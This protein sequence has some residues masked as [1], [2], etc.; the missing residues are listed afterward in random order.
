MLLFLSYCIII[1]DWYQ[2]KLLSANR[3]RWNQIWLP[4]KHLTLCFLLNQFVQA[5]KP[6]AWNVSWIDASG[7]RGGHFVLLLIQA[8]YFNVKNT[9][10]LHWWSAK[11]HKP[12]NNLQV[13]THKN[14]NFYLQEVHFFFGVC[15]F[16]HWEKKV[17]LPASETK[18]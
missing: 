15:S 1:K 13:M 7:K 4:S 16:K 3:T 17:A 10:I 14:F 6:H 2:N 8:V 18:E 9:N 12:V 11:L 5:C